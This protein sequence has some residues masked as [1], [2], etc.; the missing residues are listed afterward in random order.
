MPKP[1][2]TTNDQ[3]IAAGV[4]KPIQRT[5]DF[6][7]GFR[8]NDVVRKHAATGGMAN[9][10][11]TIPNDPRSYRTLAQVQPAWR[12]FDNDFFGFAAPSTKPDASGGGAHHSHGDLK[13]NSFR[14]LG[15]SHGGRQ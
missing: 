1:V 15:D 6:R 13:A 9:T 12:E 5:P 2:A 11:V 8:N 3:K 10:G 4:R 14:A 7:P